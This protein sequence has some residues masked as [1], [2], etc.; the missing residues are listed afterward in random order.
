M[1]KALV[2]FSGGQDSTTALAWALS[3][4]DEVETIGFDYGQ[5]HRVELDA[6]LVIREHLVALRRLRGHDR[7]GV[8]HLSRLTFPAVGDLL[9][10]NA[11][12]RADGLSS[13]FIPGRNLMF[14]VQSAALAVSRGIENVIGGMC[15]TDL[16]GFPDCRYDTM[17]A[18][19]VAV[20]L[21]MGSSLRFEFPLM[22]LG[23]AKTWWLAAKLGKEALV[24]L[25]LEDSHTCYV[26]DREQRH[27][28]GYGCGTC[29]ACVARADGW[30]QFCRELAT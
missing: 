29:D 27:V 2:L 18:L 11:V 15:E 12:P 25:I 20:N 10:D 14:M 17:A 9:A 6:R 22:R 8:D 30:A 24:D 5:R 1:S 23:K 3:K 28:W 4:F 19:Q 21:G 16:R 13:A 7:L 26:G